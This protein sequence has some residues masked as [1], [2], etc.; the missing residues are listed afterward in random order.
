MDSQKKKESGDILFLYKWD[1]WLMDKGMSL[2]FGFMCRFP[3]ASSRI[4][5]DL[6]WN[7]KS[8]LLGLMRYACVWTVFPKIR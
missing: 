8:F 1:N 7:L 5:Q 4:S 3:V 2:S 6:S